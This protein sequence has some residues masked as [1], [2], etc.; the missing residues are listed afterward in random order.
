MYVRRLTQLVYIQDVP[1]M[2][3]PLSLLPPEPRASGSA[4]RT[5]LERVLASLSVPTTHPAMRALASYSYERATAHLV[6]SWPLAPV[7]RG[8]PEI[9]QVGLGRLAYLVRTW[10]LALPSTMHLEAQGSSLAAYDRRWLEQFYL[11]AAGADRSVLPLPAQRRDGPSPEWVRAS[12]ID[13]WPPVRILFPTQ[14][15]V[16]HESVEGRM[17]GGCFFG[18]ADEY[19]KRGLRHLYAQPVSHRGNILMHAKSL[20]AID[21]KEPAHGWVY[22]G[23]HNFTRAAWGTLAGTREEP[24]LSLSNWELGVAMPLSL[25]ESDPMDAV[26]YRRPVQPY[27]LTDEPWDARTLLP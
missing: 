24:T 17:G 23:S 8:W 19:H 22:M 3:H 25:L 13:G 6:A 10:N 26:P 4:F 9:E 11:V 15:W 14:H 1:A 20:L 18:R 16:E 7:A 21:E 5:Q 12:G 27:G 2:G